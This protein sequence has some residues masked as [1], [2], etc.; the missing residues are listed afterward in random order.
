MNTK[1]AVKQTK[2]DDNDAYLSIAAFS[3]QEIERHEESAEEEQ[4]RLHDEETM[5]TQ[6]TP[7]GAFEKPRKCPSCGEGTLVLVETIP[8]PSR[9]LWISRTP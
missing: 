3:E 8:L 7:D 9:R 6:R 4:Q 1:T 5:Q 2:A